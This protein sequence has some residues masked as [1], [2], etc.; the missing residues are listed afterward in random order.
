MKTFKLTNFPKKYLHN[1]N[2]T[3]LQRELIGSIK[4]NDDFQKYLLTS[5]EIGQRLQEKIDLQVTDGKLNDARIRRQL[6][7]M[8]KS[9]LRIQNPYEIVFKD[10]SKFYGQNPI[11]LWLKVRVES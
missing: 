4:N 3:E 5:S 11:I 10:I 9:V 8:Y 6:D 7:S 1:T 2:D